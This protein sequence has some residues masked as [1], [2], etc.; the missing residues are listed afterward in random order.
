M[1]NNPIPEDVRRAA[2]N[3]LRPYKDIKIIAFPPVTLDWVLH[4]LFGS[5]RY[6]PINRTN[7]L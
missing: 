6:N 4:R 2:W 1:A 3:L 5:D 7:G